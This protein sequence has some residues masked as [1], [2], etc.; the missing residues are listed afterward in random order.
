MTVDAVSCKTVSN[1][2]FLM[3]SKKK[4]RRLNVI[5]RAA[6]PCTINVFRYHYCI[7]YYV[8]VCKLISGTT[9]HGE[10]AQ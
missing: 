6:P 8:I 3:K 10:C 2:C 4:V 1:I 9:K 7:D 5:R